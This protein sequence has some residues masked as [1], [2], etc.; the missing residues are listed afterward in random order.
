MKERLSQLLA[1]PDYNNLEQVKEVVAL[2][3]EFK[4][5]RQAKHF[6]ALSKKQHLKGSEAYHIF[7]DLK[8]QVDETEKSDLKQ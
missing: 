3:L 5:F 4:Q 8:K 1:N 7:D 2:R 6:L